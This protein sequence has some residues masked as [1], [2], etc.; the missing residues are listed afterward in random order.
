MGKV[1]RGALEVVVVEHRNAL[2]ARTP[3]GDARLEPLLLGALD[4][5]AEVLSSERKDAGV[6]RAEV[7]RRA[8]RVRDHFFGDVVSRRS[9]Y[10]LGMG[11]SGPQR[12]GIRARL[13]W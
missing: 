11:R 3:C 9:L 5:V 13:R 7:G 10:N 1:R 2:M 12:S 6:G 8:T 4:A